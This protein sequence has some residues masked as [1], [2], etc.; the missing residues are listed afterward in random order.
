MTSILKEPHERETR[1]TLEPHNHVYLIDGIPSGYISVT[2][3][4]SHFFKPFPK[5]RIIRALMNGKCKGK[6]YNQ[7]AQEWVDAAKFGEEVHA[8]IENWLTTGII[9][10]SQDPRFAVCFAQFMS[11]WK[12]LVA[13]RPVKGVRPEMRI[14]DEEYRIAGSIDLLVEFSD[15]AHE[16]FDW[17]CIF[18]ITRE[19]DRQRALTPIDHY[20]DTNLTHYT[21]QL[22]LYKYIL[23][24]NYGIKISGMHLIQLYPTQ[25]QWHQETLVSIPHD[26]E[27]VL[28]AY[29]HHSYLAP[30]ES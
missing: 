22:N 17:K 6:T 1:I 26:I 8:A 21:L 9:P 3:L 13:K 19:N 30:I 18:K 5:D 24:K 15:G 12:E 28:L 10:S 23:E 11:F 4:L 20:D 14:F 25:T 2:T 27:Q 7:I 29:S 16:L